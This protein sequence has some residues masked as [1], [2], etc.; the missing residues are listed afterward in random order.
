LRTDALRIWYFGDIVGRIGRTAVAEYV[1]AKGSEYR[2]DLIVANG[3]NAAGGRGID[4]T[5]AEELQDAGID[6]LTTGNH[7]WQHPGIS[8]YLE[9]TTRVLRPANYPPQSPGVGWTVVHS[10]GGEVKV[11]VLNLIGRVFM[12][13]ADC[14]FRI[15]DEAVAAMQR[16]TPCILVDMHG[17]ATSEKA[18]IAAYLQGR[19]SAVIGSHTHVQT[20][21]ERVLGGHTA[22]LTDAGMCGPYD[23]IIGVR[24]DRVVQRFLDQRPNRF[25]VATG[26]AVVQGASLALDPEN[27]RALSIERVRVLPEVALALDSP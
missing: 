18:A 9:E 5:T 24:S 3:E 1:R 19:V 17:E 23:S 10:K 11:G 2:P 8:E 27:G 6:V 15:A 4:P 16:E 25:D 22:F 14:P 20:A 7:V 26:P 12:G 13:P 21:D